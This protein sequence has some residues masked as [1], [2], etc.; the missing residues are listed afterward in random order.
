[1][2]R[3]LP[4]L[5][6]DNI[7]QILGNFCY[8]WDGCSPFAVVFNGYGLLVQPRMFPEG[9]GEGLNLLDIKACRVAAGNLADAFGGCW[10]VANLKGEEE[11][12]LTRDITKAKPDL[13]F[14][15]TSTGR[16]SVTTHTPSGAVWTQLC[17]DDQFGR[18]IGMLDTA[19]IVSFTCFK[20]HELL[21]QEKAEAPERARIAKMMRVPLEPGPMA[22]HFG[23]SVADLN[24]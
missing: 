18:F 11:T 9:R 4:F 22:S 10:F 2:S 16:L 15:F 13:L 1:M 3:F 24:L 8:T 6:G 21:K 17:D 7:H 12:I 19:R 14:Q 20:Y 23:D 5:T